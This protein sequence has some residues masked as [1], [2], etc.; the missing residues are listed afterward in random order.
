MPVISP[1]P[2]ANVVHVN[3]WLHKSF[4]PENIPIVAT[5]HS[6][7][8]DSAL[9]PYKGKLQSLYHRLWV[10]RCEK[11]MLGLAQAV[12]AVSQYTADI[13]AD[14]FGRVD[15]LPILNWS[16]T[17]GF[18]PDNRTALHVPFRL[19]FMGNMSRRKGADLLP[20]IMRQLGSDFVLRYTGTA[21]EVDNCPSNMIPLGRLQGTESIL[22]AY[23]NCDALLFPTRLEGLPLTVLEAL[24]S[25]RPIITTDCCSLPEVVE[26][27]VTGILCPIDDTVAFANAARVLR[28]NPEM[29]LRMCVAARDK[30]TTRF[31]EDNAIDSYFQLYTSLIADAELRSA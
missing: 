27:D 28:D 12:T 31:S 17:D 21:D 13:S 18:R 11:E 8:H 2:W 16:D 4:V 1:P 30:A 24:A 10:K 9:G 20:E 15:I 22:D 23:R 14:I 25:G 5:I 26:H 6:C 19:L 7:V 29:W 3:S